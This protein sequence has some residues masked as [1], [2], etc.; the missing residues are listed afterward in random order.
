M[1]LRDLSIGGSRAEALGAQARVGGGS[2]FQYQSFNT[3]PMGILH[4]GIYLAKVLK[5]RTHSFMMIGHGKVDRCNTHQGFQLEPSPDLRWYS[6][7]SL[8]YL[9]SHSLGNYY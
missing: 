6:G 3:E 1:G 2:G 8:P 9:S 5:D 7:H 4:L